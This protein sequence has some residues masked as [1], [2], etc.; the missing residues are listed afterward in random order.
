MSLKANYF[1]LGLFVIGAVIAGVVL[2]VVIGSGRWFQ[3]KLMVET[4]FNESVQGLEIGSKLKYRGV[5]IGEVT[6]IGFTYNTYQLDRPMAQR[7][8][9]VLVEAQI[10]PKLLG[11]RAA[12][13]DLTST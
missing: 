3:P 8:R 13:G 9:Y 6:R 12:A 5:V 2:L 10:Q 7:E 4:Y 11:G 1:K